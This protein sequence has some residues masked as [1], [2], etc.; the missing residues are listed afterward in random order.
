LRLP[1]KDT[2][3]LV[4]YGKVTYEASVAP[5]GMNAVHLV[6]RAKV[7]GLLNDISDA[8]LWRELMGERFTTRMLRSWVP[9]LREKLREENLLVETDGV[10]H[11]H[12]SLK[13]D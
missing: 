3:R 10:R 7:P 1:E 2:E 9:W 5:V 13:G 11:N 6:A 4:K 12:L 8:A